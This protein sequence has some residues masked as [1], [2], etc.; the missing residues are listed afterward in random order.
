M[1]RGPGGKALRRFIILLC[2]SC[3]DLP[4]PAYG[5]HL[6][7]SWSGAAAGAGSFPVRGVWCEQPGLL[8]ITAVTGDTGV[9]LAVY[10]HDS[11]LVGDYPVIDPA[12]STAPR[13][14]AAVA[15]RWFTEHEVAGYQS[16]SGT[17]VVT[18]SSARLAGSF[19][20]RLR[21]L[22]RVDTI[23]VSGRFTNVRVT[24]ASPSECPTDRQPID[25]A[26]P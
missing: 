8:R 23:R 25:S 2:T 16:D 24:P 18:G 20:A 10:A 4:W 3:T 26:S 5:P 1:R 17:V 12:D 14:G 21:S 19:E 15:L 7:A 13:M 22:N 11:L 6:Q 9:G